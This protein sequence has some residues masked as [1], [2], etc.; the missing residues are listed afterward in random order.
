MKVNYISVH[1]GH[2]LCV[3]EL[4]FLQISQSIKQSVAIKVSQG[5]TSECNP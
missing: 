5:V 2:E 3:S 1:Q 4:P